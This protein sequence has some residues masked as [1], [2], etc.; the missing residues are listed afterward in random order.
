QIDP[1]KWGYHDYLINRLLT[2]PTRQLSSFIKEYNDKTLPEDV[3][4]VM[5]YYH[6]DN[7]EA[8]YADLNWF[9]KSLELGIFKRIQMP[10]IVVISRGAFG[11]DYRESQLRFEDFDVSQLK[12]E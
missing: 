8:F 11:Y 6:L 9:M 3:K 5:A 2:Y 10:P 4:Q 1:M 7:Q 12:K